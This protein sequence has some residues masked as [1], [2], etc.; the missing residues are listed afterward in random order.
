M[1]NKYVAIYTEH[2]KF[3]A[4]RFEQIQGANYRYKGLYIYGAN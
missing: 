4:L 2:S 1:Y 3:C